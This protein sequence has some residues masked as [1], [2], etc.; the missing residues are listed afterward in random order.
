MGSM[1]A[2]A[3]QRTGRCDLVAAADLQPENVEAFASSW[4]DAATYLDYRAM[5]GEARP[6]IVS[7][8]TWPHL[9]AEM[10]IA[11]AEAGVKA[12]HCEKP[13]AKT[14]ADARRMAEACAQAGTQL[15]INHQNRF[16]EPYQVARDL[17]RGG[18]IGELRSLQG[19]SSNLFNS[20]WL[21]L[22]F[23]YN[24]ETPVEW[25]SAQMDSRSARTISSEPREA[26]SICSFQFVNG[27]HALLL[28]GPNAEI[29][30]VS[31]LIGTEGSIE[32]HGQAPRVRVH[33]KRDGAWR[34]IDVPDGP[35][36][37]P[38]LDRAI[39]DVVGALDEDREP[40]LSGRRA[41]QS[42]EVIFAAYESDRRWSRV[43]LPLRTEELPVL[44]PL[45]PGDPGSRA[46]RG[47]AGGEN[48]A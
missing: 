46:A 44:A 22:L 25:V 48:D 40:E 10:V 7:V 34:S 33:R 1:H 26:R 14:W 21:D 16:R 6:E 45:T 38:P 47:I 41:L 32:V 2:L 37:Q 18:A 23:F 4:C 3:Y 42:L 9:H 30:C 5:L 43:E 39:A 15:T 8:C 36:W 28:T 24:D 17:V 11:C 27:V 31:R 20:H 13:M 35:D 19:T 29:G 12:V